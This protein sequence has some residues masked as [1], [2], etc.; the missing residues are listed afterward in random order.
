MRFV[1]IFLVTVIFAGDIS[2]IY[3]QGG[4]EK[5]AQSVSTSL[6]LLVFYQ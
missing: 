3:G 2:H 6:I 4:E 1:Y 5:H